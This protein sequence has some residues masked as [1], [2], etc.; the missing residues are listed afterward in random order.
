MLFRE[1]LP[2]IIISYKM[3]NMYDCGEEPTKKKIQI[4]LKSLKPGQE[5]P[6][7]NDWMSPDKDPD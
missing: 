1:L 5:L 2:K 4:L 7:L 3:I 6:L